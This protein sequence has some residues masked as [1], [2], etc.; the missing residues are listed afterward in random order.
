VTPPRNTVPD[1]GTAHV[2]FVLNFNDERRR[3]VPRVK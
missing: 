3:R 2:T 1:A